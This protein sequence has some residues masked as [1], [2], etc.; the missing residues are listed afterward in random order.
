MG[1]EIYYLNTILRRLKEFKEMISDTI[2]MPSLGA[3]ALAD[4][5]EWLDNYIYS[6]KK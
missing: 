5:I 3:E 6:K 4:E 2:P 1:D